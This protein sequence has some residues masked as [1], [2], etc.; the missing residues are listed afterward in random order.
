MDGEGHLLLA[1][2]MYS[3]GWFLLLLLLFVKV[4]S[5][6]WFKVEML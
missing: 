2:G 5:M 6:M 1:D 4:K 3:I